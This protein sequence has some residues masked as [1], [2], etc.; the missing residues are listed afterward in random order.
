MDDQNNK[1]RLY[2]I[3]VRRD[4]ND[5]CYRDLK[6]LAYYGTLPSAHPLENARSPDFL[7]VPAGDWNFGTLVLSDCKTKFT[8]GE[9]KMVAL[10]DELG[11]QSGGVKWCTT[12]VNDLDLEELTW[13]DTSTPV[14]SSVSITT[15]QRFTPA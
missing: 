12:T 5:S 8:I 13:T 1:R 2:R 14:T 9:V 7:H 3:R 6:Y 11:L 4:K 15:T 10:D